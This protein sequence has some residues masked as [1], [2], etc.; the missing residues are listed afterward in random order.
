MI[1]FSAYNPTRLDMFC[2][3]TAYMP[4]RVIMVTGGS[5]TEKTTFYDIDT[6]TWIAGPDM[7]LPR[8]YHSMTLLEGME[9]GMQNDR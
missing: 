4:G 5:T 9:S 2:P 8:G 3:G 7:A 6:D 1:T